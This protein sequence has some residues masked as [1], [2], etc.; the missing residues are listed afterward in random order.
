VLDRANPRC[1]PTGARARAF[2]GKIV[3]AGPN[4]LVV[5]AA[6]GVG[7]SI[8]ATRIQRGLPEGSVGI[9]YDCFGNGE[10]RSASSYRHRH[11]DALVEMAN[12]LAGKG[13]CH[14]LIPTTRARPSDYAKAFLYRLTQSV[15]SVVARNRNALLCLVIDAADNAQMAATEAG[16]ARSFVLDLIREKIPEGVRLVPDYPRV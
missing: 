7:K 3:D 15:S 9:L 1:R 11:E 4:P 8:F 14:P 6:G 13:L 2:I 10:Y 12:E 5:D 16:E